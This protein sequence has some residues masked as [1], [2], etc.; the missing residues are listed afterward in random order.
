MI[1]R[2][3]FSVRDYGNSLSQIFEK[4]FVKAM[5]LIKK[6]LNSWFD[7]FFSVRENFTFFHTVVGHSVEIPGFF[8][9]SDFMWNQFWCAEILKLPFWVRRYFVNLYLECW[10]LSNSKFRDSQMANMTLFE[11]VEAPKL[12]SC[13]IFWSLTLLSMHWWELGGR[14]FESCSRGEIFFFIFMLTC[15]S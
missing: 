8:C 3:F 11:I 5:G 1:W 14:G 9:H 12:I 6:L 7:E 2:I 4:N 15:N 10:N 13:E